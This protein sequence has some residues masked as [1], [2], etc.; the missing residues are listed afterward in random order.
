MRNSRKFRI[1]SAVMKHM[2][3]F[4]QI[5]Y[6]EFLYNKKIGRKLNWDNL[7]AYT[8]K[9]QWSKLYDATDIKTELSDK[10]LVRKWVEEKIGKDYLIPLLGV[11]NNYDEIDFEKLPNQFVLK[12]NHGSGTVII[13]KDKYKIN[14]KLS[15]QLFDDWMNT[16][17]SYLF[18]MEMQY[19]KIKRKIIAE[20][21]LDT[22]DQ[23]LQDYKF[24]CF[25]GRPYFCWVDLDRF[26]NHTRNVYD[27][28]WNIQPWNQYTYGNSKNDI[29][30][31]KNF[32]KMVEIA[33]LL[34]VGFSHVRVDLYNINGK[35]YFGEMTFT[36]GSGYERI[37]PD[38]Y[39]FKLGKLWNIDLSKK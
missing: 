21:Y 30:K 12:T 7:C 16:D 28:N 31:P 32:E 33:S 15:R 5:K 17:Y 1:V 22:G 27:L 14:H 20:Q 26:K 6:I 38:E 18:G 3:R 9:M 23:D 37:V 4:V 19:T 34:C 24:L 35:I 25:D 29:P 10:Y 2:P 36:N 39:D 13:V 8:E 11:W